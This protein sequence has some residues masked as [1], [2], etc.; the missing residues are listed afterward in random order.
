MAH[1]QYTTPHGFAGYQGYEIS[2]R[3]SN[4]SGQL[5]TDKSNTFFA[6]ACSTTGGRAACLRPARAGRRARW[7]SRQ[8]TVGTPIPAPTP[9]PTPTPTPHTDADADPDDHDHSGPTPTATP[10]P[11]PNV[12]LRRRPPTNVAGAA[13][14]AASSQNTSTGQT[15]AKAIDGARDLRLPRR[16]HQRIEPRSARPTEPPP[17]SPSTQRL[18]LKLGPPP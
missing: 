16:L 6:Y 12:R 15:A 17:P 11:T 4:V 2:L 13:S 9:T 1:E 5:Q 18:R 10:T 14:V 7:L 8:Y 3:G